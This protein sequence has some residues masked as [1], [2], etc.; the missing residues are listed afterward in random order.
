MVFYFDSIIPNSKQNKLYVLQR[1]YDREAYA[2]RISD[3]EEK[4]EIQRKSLEDLQQER[5]SLISLIKELNDEVGMFS[6]MACT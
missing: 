4:L 2:K 1:Y 3:L 5:G 6:Q